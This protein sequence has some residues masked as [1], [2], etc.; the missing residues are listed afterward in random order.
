MRLVLDT[1][2]VLDLF[3]FRDV[4]V[5]GLNRALANKEVTW[6]AT[7]AMR[8]EL[9]SVLSYEQ[10]SA[11]MTTPG[12]SAPLVLAA[13][14]AHAELVDAPPASSIKCRDT[15]DQKFVDLAAAHDALLLSKD[16]H[17][18]TLRRKLRVARAFSAPAPP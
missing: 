10:I 3:V 2:I 9:A 8:D 7:A 16:A 13:F 11:R 4:A 5:D 17:L 14:D 6:L 1:N 12:H 18:L 15:D